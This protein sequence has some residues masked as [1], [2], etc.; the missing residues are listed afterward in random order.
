MA[1][2][3]FLFVDQVG[4]T[5][6]LTRLGDREAHQLRRA[7]FD[8]LRQATE[9]A[10]GHE[11][12]FTGD[13]LFCAF[14]GAADGVEAAVAMQQLAVSFNA[15]RPE[16]HHLSVRIG[17]NTGEPLDSEGG[18]YFGSAVV[19]AARLCSAATAGQVL[20]SGL[21]RSLVEPR[22]THAFRPVGRLELK[23]VPE[24]L[25][26]FSVDWSPDERRGQLPAQLAAAR[27]GPFAGRTRELAEISAAWDRV[28]E[29]GRAVVLVSGDRGIGV[30]RLLAEAAQ[31]LQERGASVWA[32]AGQGADAH[33]A[34]WAQAVGEWAAATARAELRL[35]MGARAADLL[36]LAPG[37]AE[38]V[39]R[40][41]APPASA[42][43]ADV[44]L[45]SDAVDELAT[46]WSSVEPLVIV[47]D[48]LEQADPGT[49]TVLRRLVE[50]RRA[51]RVLV[52]AGYEPAGVG[53]SRLQQGLQSIDGAVDL[54]LSGL[55]ADEVQWLLTE[56]AGEPAPEAFLRGVLAESEGSPYFVLQMARSV[57]ERSITRHVQEAV[58]RAGELRTDLRL[59]REE[60]SLAL[61]QLDQLRDTSA[62]TEQARIDPDGTPPG[63]GEPPYRGLL[64]FQTEDAETFCG[65]D[66]LVAEM[67]AAL[68]SGSLLTVVGAS[69][70]GKSSAVRAGL[71]PALARGA[72]PGS[73][74]WASAVCTPG[75]DPLGALGAALAGVR[76]GDGDGLAQ[77][78]AT[79]PLTALAAD[80][81]GGVELVLVVDQFEELWTTSPE[82]AR[83][84]ML[85][86]L[87]EN[88]GDTRRQVLVVICLRADYFGLVSEEPGLAGLLAQ[89]Q[90]VVSPMTTGELRAAVEPPAR[91]GGWLLEP[92]LAQA[93]IDDVTDQPGALPLLSTAMLE[94][95]QRRR[96]RSMTLA[97]YTETGGARR[98]IA[99]LA[100]ST[101]DELE[102]RQQEVARRLLLRL[103]APAA[104]GG[105]IA[106]L[107][108][109]AELVVDDDAR[110]VLAR[111]ADRRLVSVG[112]STAQVSHEALLREWPRLRGWLEA[113][114]EGRRLHQQVAAAA[115]E[116]D[117][118]G[119]DD[120]ALLRGARLAAAEERRAA[121][122]DELTELERQYMTASTRSRRRG[123]RRLRVVAGALVVLLLGA[124]VG[125]ALAVVNGRAAAARANEATA[126]GL[127]AQAAA[128]V[129]SQVDTALVLAVEGHRRDPS[130]DTRTGLLTA[131]NGAR[132]LESVVDGL[133]VDAFDVAQSPDGDRLAVLTGDG[134]LQLY[135]PRELRPS[136]PPLVQDMEA[137]ST[138]E[139]SPDGRYLAYGD[140]AGVHVLEADTGDEVGPALGGGMYA[141]FS[142]SSDGSVLAVAG[143]V[144]SEL[145]IR[146]VD[147]L[148]GRVLG[149]I[150]AE[151]EGFVAVRPGHDELVATLRPG[152][153]R[154]FRFD[155][156]PIGAPVDMDVE[157]TLMYT[158][159]GSRLM[160]AATASGQFFDAE[161]LAAVGR[162]F[163]TTGSRF[164]D[165]VFSPNGAALVT[166]GDDGSILVVDTQDGTE[167]HS[168]NGLA[169]ACLLG[170]LS[171]TRLL[172]LS[173]GGAAQ[174][175]LADLTPIG[176]SAFVPSAVG[177]L[178][179]LPGGDRVLT[180]FAGQLV[181]VD[182][183]AAVHSTAS[184]DLPVQ[185][186]SV[187]QSPDE[188]RVALI[189]FA[190][191]QSA[192]RALVVDRSSGEV[193]VDVP[194]QE[195]Y[196]GGGGRVSFSPDGRRFAVGSSDGSVTVFDTDSGDRLAREQVDSFGVRALVWSPGGELFQGGQ[197]GV[198]RV[199]D[200]DTLSV[201]R[202][203]PLSE[204]LNLSDIAPV[205]GSELVATASEDGLVRFVDPSTG[206]VVGDPL[207]ADGTQLQSVAVSGDGRLVGAVSR[208]GAL[209]LWDRASGRAVGPPLLGHDQ[210]AL[211]IAWL[212]DGTLVTASLGG[213][214]IAW[215][216]SPDAWADRACELAGRDL[217]RGEWTRYLPSEPYR[218]TC[219]D[220]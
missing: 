127:A 108:P 193:L 150:P 178:V 63:A 68:V 5:E 44:F 97:G 84:R 98:A 81:T 103:A 22:G 42:P 85:D 135:D 118:G 109:L 106:R 211:G 218:R 64:A 60:I 110:Q 174:L 6:Q 8:T 32:G 43:A 7:L 182:A 86:L 187:A 55:S 73:S 199:L 205:P 12:D 79:E 136:G 88:A 184:E 175:D 123:V 208:D 54:R 171:D 52:L 125:G 111:L 65:R 204:Q 34:A 67:V 170:F 61:R 56:V 220:R 76:G 71:L 113:D 217:T 162:R 167:L 190:D 144:Q 130:I 200:P 2:T 197:D 25:E 116:W 35:A 91:R 179:P 1:T 186:I 70:S 69:G 40:L 100:D 90:V 107:A 180:G 20:A 37:L 203:V 131:L 122:E 159:D 49:L 168:A 51:G 18:G 165:G 48:A 46:R 172:C 120:G 176:R 112:A 31:R 210:Q 38:L 139:F 169:Q 124:V 82:Q 201:V 24:P 212:A 4:S 188:R 105:D 196:A 166:S 154:R 181:E 149:S 209:R 83:R 47:L 96:G 206:Q 126:R 183:D 95:W 75:R 27:T 216:T 143:G 102:P 160:A 132:F 15:R 148:S 192:V 87:V 151:S 16:S 29:G 213:S 164:R 177:H 152:L 80:A 23:G 215:D 202:Q 163:S 141:W 198:F 14:D 155:G 161:S 10:G 133:P 17:L 94:T 50:S 128:L 92:G 21:V 72:L 33:L 158:P 157:S 189:G 145:G 142:F 195:G 59:Q 194:V 119:R 53:A 77:R 138:V 214:L 3:T 134:A 153:A 173:P 62:G 41:P 11:V 104:R 19:V 74:Q 156:T 9:L 137:P 207:T 78:S 114:R 117:A 28:T 58:D 30:S 146:V 129:E 115:V 66:A 147:T 93:V 45:I 185:V 140:A 101:L 121:H 99:N 89:A 26:T 39:P 219:S 191:D 57:K 13:G 36:R